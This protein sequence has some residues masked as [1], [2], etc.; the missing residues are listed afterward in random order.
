MPDQ[1]KLLQNRLKTISHSGVLSAQQRAQALQQY[2]DL[3]EHVQNWK[4]I[5]WLRTL[6]TNCVLG[7]NSDFIIIDRELC[8]ILDIED[9][10]NVFGILKV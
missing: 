9:L 6:I 8:Y 10:S 5:E 4:G 7:F 1:L 2:R 3:L